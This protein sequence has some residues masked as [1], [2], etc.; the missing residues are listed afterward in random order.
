MVDGASRD[1]AVPPNHVVEVMQKGYLIGE[2]VIRP[3]LVIVSA[4]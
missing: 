3:A 1:P 2:R 4:P